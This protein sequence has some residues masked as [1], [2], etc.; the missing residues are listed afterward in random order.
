MCFTLVVML[1]HIMS[2]FVSVTL[3]WWPLHFAYCFLKTFINHLI[4]EADYVGFYDIIIYAKFF[5]VSQRLSHLSNAIKFSIFQNMNGSTSSNF[6]KRNNHHMR[7]TD[8]N[9]HEHDTPPPQ[10]NRAITSSIISNS[11]PDHSDLDTAIISSSPQQQ[12]AIT[13]NKLLICPWRPHAWSVYCPL[14]GCNGCATCTSFVIAAILMLGV[15]WV[16]VD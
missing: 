11:C 2:D 9:N 16:G 13:C 7:Q 6:N 8:K 4:S 14:W 1:F 12:S 15:V 3:V 5:K 10:L